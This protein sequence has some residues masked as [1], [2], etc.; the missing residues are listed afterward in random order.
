VMTTP[1]TVLRRLLRHGRI[2]ACVALCTALFTQSVWA[3]AP[4]PDGN[5][6]HLNRLLHNPA[7]INHLG[8]SDRQAEAAQVASNTVVENH[9]AEFDAAAAYD[10]RDARVAHVARLFVTITEQ[11]FAQLKDVLSPAQHQRLQQIELQTFALRAFA[12][13]A[14]ASALGLTDAQQ[15]ALNT[16]AAEA[17]QQ[18]QAIVQSQTLSATEKARQNQKIRESALQNVRQ[19]LNAGQWVKWELLTGARFGF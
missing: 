13:P 1:A 10:T 8:L 15:R 3:A 12:R 2:G 18:T 4:G 19:Q 17:G 16:I 14:V 6:G 7:V 5:R 9:R 11:T